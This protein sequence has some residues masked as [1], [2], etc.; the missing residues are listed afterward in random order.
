MDAEEQLRLRARSRRQAIL[1]VVLMNLLILFVASTA[2]VDLRR[3]QTRQGVALRWFQA[4]VFGDCKDY[5]TYSTSDPDSSDSRSEG[6]LCT[7]LRRQRAARGDSLK[8]GFRLGE[9]EQ[10]RV[11]VVL[12]RAGETKDVVMHVVWR[13]GRWLVLRDGVTCNSVACA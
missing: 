11:H 7:D 10:D 3:L 13:D 9:I 12:T 1:L 8:I 5:L 2:V 6:E 4:A